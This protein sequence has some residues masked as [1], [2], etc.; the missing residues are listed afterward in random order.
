MT[1]IEQEARDLLNGVW[2]AR[3]GVSPWTICDQRHRHNVVEAVCRALEQRNAVQKELDD[4]RREVSDA[5]YRYFQHST[6]ADEK[7]LCSFILPAPI[8]PKVAALRE[9]LKS[10]GISDP[11]DDVLADDFA[12]LDA[13]LAEHGGEVVFKGN[14]AP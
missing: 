3:L 10:R 12:R 9:W 1:D 13:V 2:A 5:I 8:D 6:L 4:S 14:D 11:N 7:H